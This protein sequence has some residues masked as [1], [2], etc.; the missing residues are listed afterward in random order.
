MS[1]VDDRI[2]TVMMRDTARKLSQR[3]EIPTNSFDGTVS[4]PSSRDSFY[5]ALQIEEYQ[6]L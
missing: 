3:C 4:D 1:S 2:L 6:E 5:T